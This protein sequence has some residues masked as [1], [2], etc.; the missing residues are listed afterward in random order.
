MVGCLP[1]QPFFYDAINE[2]PLTN[3]TE[4]GTSTIIRRVRLL[5]RRAR[6]V[7]FLPAVP[8]DPANRSGRRLLQL[9]RP[10][11]KAGD[12]QTG[13]GENILRAQSQVPPRLLHQRQRRRAAGKYRQVVVAQ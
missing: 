12:R 1:T 9:L 11:A 2:T 10:A 3:G 13:T 7:A 5:R 4:A 6:G 8:Q